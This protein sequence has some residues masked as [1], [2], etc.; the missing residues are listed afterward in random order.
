MNFYGLRKSFTEADY[1]EQGGHLRDKLGLSSSVD[2]MK[3]ADIDSSIGF[4]TVHENEFLRILFN[5]EAS[6][7]AD[8]MFD[9]VNT[10]HGVLGQNAPVTPLELFYRREKKGDD[11]RFMTVTFRAL[12]NVMP[13][14]VTDCIV[15]DVEQ[16]RDAGIDWVCFKNLW[17]SDAYGE[18]YLKIPTRPI[19]SGTNGPL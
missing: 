9:A 16:L 18:D 11:K 2:V 17:T 12:N 1:R 10:L 13:R 3:D 7:S 19:P 14:D 8:M 4:R 15:G 6:E 5:W